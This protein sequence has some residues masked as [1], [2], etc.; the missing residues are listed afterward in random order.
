CLSPGSSC[1]PTSYNCCR[2]CNPYSRKC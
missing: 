2:S 1:S